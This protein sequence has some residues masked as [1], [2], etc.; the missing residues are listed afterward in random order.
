MQNQIK[1]ADEDDITQIATRYPETSPRIYRNALNKYARGEIS[2]N[3]MNKIHNALL[4]NMVE[5][6]P[7]QK[8]KTFDK[9]K[10]SHY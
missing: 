9:I 3:D 7:K 6:I 10:F 8:F 4:V 2:R 1:K 5:Y